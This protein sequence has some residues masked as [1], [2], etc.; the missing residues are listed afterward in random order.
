MSERP[1]LDWVEKNS[2]RVCIGCWE[3]FCEMCVNE[4][5]LSESCALRAKHHCPAER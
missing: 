2:E 3:R 4:E 1:C 5:Y